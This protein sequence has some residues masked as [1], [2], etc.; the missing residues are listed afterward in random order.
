VFSEV[1]TQEEVFDEVRPL[2]AD[3]LAG[4]NGCI[5]A[6]GQTSAGKTHTMLGPNGGTNLNVPK[7]R[8]GILPRSAEYLFTQL[9]ELA[10]GGNFRYTAKAS[11]LQIYKERLYD[12]L[13][14]SGSFE[15]DSGEG[16]GDLRIRE[17]PRLQDPVTGEKY[18]KDE[19]RPSEVFITGTFE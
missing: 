1:T 4:Y 2:L 18:K 19:N 6:Y 11:F 5:F 16:E 12:L 17:I 14:G 3:V 8:W 7:E 9:E 13:R 10:A 15:D